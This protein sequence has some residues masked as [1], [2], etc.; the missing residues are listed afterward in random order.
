V[1]RGPMQRCGTLLVFK[2]KFRRQ[3]AT[4]MR[5]R[6]AA[7]VSVRLSRGFRVNFAAATM[8]FR[9]TNRQ[10]GH[11]PAAPASSTSRQ[12]LH[13]SRRRAAAT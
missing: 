4:R 10:H 3:I 11:Q 12:Q 1:L 6:A 5:M 9:V 8:A 2:L 13:P 7:G